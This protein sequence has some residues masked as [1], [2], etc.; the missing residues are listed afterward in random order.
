MHEMETV[1]HITVPPRP[2]WGRLVEKSIQISNCVC[3]WTFRLKH[4]NLTGKHFYFEMSPEA[5]WELTL[6]VTDSAR[7]SRLNWLELTCRAYVY[8]VLSISTHH[9]SALPRVWASQYIWP[10]L[11]E[12]DV[13]FWAAYEH[14]HWLCSSREAPKGMNRI[15]DMKCGVLHMMN[16]PQ[17]VPASAQCSHIIFLHSLSTV[18]L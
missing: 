2:Q 5:Q 12:W 1:F 10:L 4:F 9:K 17:S 15:A 3:S 8:L 18:S 6:N 14:W 7:F 16:T 11:W 13:A